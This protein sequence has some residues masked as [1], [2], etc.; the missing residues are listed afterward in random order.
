MNRAQLT[1]YSAIAAV[2]SILAFGFSIVPSMHEFPL[3]ASL[4]D[5]GRLDV[6]MVGSRLEPLVDRHLIDRL[7]G[8]A[9]LKLQKPTP[10]E[11]VQIADKPWEGNTSA[12]YT[13]L[14]DGEL[15]RMYYRGSHFDEKT[16]ASAHREVA[17]YAES[18]DGLHWHKPNLGLFDFN[19]S[20]DNNIV[21][22][23]PGSHNFTPFKDSNPKAPPEARY[24]ALAGGSKGLLAFRSADGIHWS[25]IAD[26]PVITRGNFDSQNLAFWDSV[27][28]KYREYH[29]T[30]HGVRDIM[31]GTSDD[32]VNW[33]DPV[34]LSYPGAPKEHLYTNAI[35]PYERAPH[36]LLGFPTRFLPETQQTEPIFMTSRDGQT[37]QRWHEAVIPK[38]APKDRDGNRS[39]YMAWGLVRLPGQE[40]E[41]SVFAKEAYYTGTGSRV[42]RF[43][44]RVDG[45]V[46]VHAS[47]TGGEMIT[48][49]LR[50]QGSKLVLNYKLE[51]GGNL[52]VELQDANGKPILNRSLADCVELKGDNIAEVVAW[53]TGDDL[54]RWAEKP[55][56]IRFEIKQGDLFSFQFK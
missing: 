21:W 7:G 11:V 47:D 27:L 2:L 23:G 12:Y 39:N 28:G 1:F 35:R 14:Q 6:L 50:F 8:T 30:T 49:A 34:F 13:I 4:A 33:T 20:K 17:C 43:T 9:E 31:T 52:R 40:N 55:I 53:K 15:Y 54:T 45:F 36:I 48:K 25:L 41:L 18:K 56:R 24:K 29:R 46:S 16:K 51:S 5:D 44:Y 26:K 42:R 32:F 37:F 10:G 19:G 22:D 38:S 3:N